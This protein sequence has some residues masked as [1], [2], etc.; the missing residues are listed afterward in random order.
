MR[1][2][3]DIKMM[4]LLMA[5]MREYLISPFAK[6]KG[7]DQHVHMRSLISDS[8][9]RYLENNFVKLVP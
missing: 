4:T 5:T 7:T 6:T 8:M 2:R 1:S 9:Y 3:V